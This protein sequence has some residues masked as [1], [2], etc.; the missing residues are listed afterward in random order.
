MQFL[1]LITAIIISVSIIIA[2][3][4]AIE[5]A[6]KAFNLS[7][8]TVVGNATHYIISADGLI[9]ES[10]Y[11]ELKLNYP[12]LKF[13]PVI[14]DHITYKDTLLNVLGVDLFAESEFRPFLA[15][16]DKD[17][18]LDFYINSQ[19]AVLL[20][21]ETAD[22]FNWTLNKDIKLTIKETSQTIRPYYLLESEDNNTS[23]AFNNLLIMDLSSAQKILNKKSQLTRLDLIIPKGFKLANFKAKLVADHPDL[24]VISSY[25]QNQSVDNMTNSFYTNLSALSLLAMLVG[26]FLIYNSMT[27]SVLQRR[28][29]LAIYR[30]LGFSASELFSSIIFEVSIISVIGTILGII[31]GLLLAKVLVVL[32]LQTINDLYFNL[33]VAKV[34]LNLSSILKGAAVGILAAIVSALI[35][36]FEAANVK[37]VQALSRA[38][39]ERKFKYSV[40]IAFIISIILAIASYYTFKYSGSSIPLSFAG[41]FLTVISFA[42][43]VPAVVITLNF[44]INLIFNSS[45]FL[46]IR[47]AINSLSRHLSRNVVAIVALSIALSLYLALNISVKSFRSTVS[48][49][50]E[51]SLKADIYITAPKLIS[52]KNI[53]P[54][55]NKAIN[56]IREFSENKVRGISEFYQREALS[57]EFGKVN[58]A[59]VNPLKIGRDS[60]KWINTIADDE[61]ILWD[62]FEAGTGVI[63]SQ[64]FS[65]KYKVK[66]GDELSIYTEQGLT[67]LTILAVFFDYSSDQGIV[68]MNQS[69]LNQYFNKKNE[70]NNLGIYLN[71]S[72]EQSAEKYI[73]EL[74][75]YLKSHEFSTTKLALS[76]SSSLKRESMMIF[77]RTFRITDILKIIAILVA[78]FGILSA[79]MSLIFERYHEFAIFRALGMTQLELS[80][81][82]LY[83]AIL[84]AVYAWLLAVPLGLLEAWI[85]IYVIN[86]RSFGWSINYSFEWQYAAFALGIALLAAVCA[87]IYPSYQLSKINPGILLKDE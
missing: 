82:N 46:F 45:K 26:V 31:S 50:L 23:Q 9:D 12:E 41:L 36:A 14:E 86:F 47:I 85:M 16:N 25:S 42:L 35:P 77:D 24:N 73:A 27:F 59:G 54:L 7:T 78:F 57:A 17:F 58:L 43:L 79:L 87:V 30:S 21:K 51:D 28:K 63:I 55:P 34:S 39:Y 5:N 4:M 65:S 72:S 32:V 74:K 81:I 66:S 6:K 53:D 3:D 13:A 80:Q 11:P 20:S 40:V 71:N 69:S 38:N 22:K 1:T 44:I 67:K 56:L 61:S 18:D 83:Q 8:Q 60:F 64:P 19:K 52:N 62:S 10:L 70:I 15:V 48:N 33:E 2:T 68:I 49:W 84:M 75:Q 29:I 37:P 76:S